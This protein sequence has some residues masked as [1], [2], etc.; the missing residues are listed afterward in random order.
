MFRLRLALQLI[1]LFS[2]PAITLAEEGL[3]FTSSPGVVQMR[4]EVVASSGAI[5]YNSDWKNGNVFDWAM[6]ALPY[7]SY[8]VRIHSRDLEG[9][10]SEKMT[11][12]QVGPEGIKVDPAAGNDLKL[13]AAFHDGETGELVTSSG[14]LSFRFGDFLNRRDTEVMR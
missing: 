1:A 9:R 7:G 12:L 2:S 14:D 5:L 8:S 11:T 6:P 13:T 3:R 10:V 4:V